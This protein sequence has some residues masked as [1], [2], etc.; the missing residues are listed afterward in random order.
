MID[1]WLLLVD[2]YDVFAIKPECTTSNADEVYRMLHLWYFNNVDGLKTEYRIVDTMI[3][4]VTYYTTAFVPA[5]S[6]MISLSS[7]A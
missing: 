3:S 4:N 5:T 1:L 7:N 6:R 2:Q